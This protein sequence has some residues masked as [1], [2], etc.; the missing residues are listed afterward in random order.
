MGKKTEAFP[1]GTPQHRNKVL[2]ERILSTDTNKIPE[3]ICLIKD[4]EPMRTLGQWVGND[5]IIED[6]WRKYRKR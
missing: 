6:K 2:T 5:I 1:I 3:Y 4:D